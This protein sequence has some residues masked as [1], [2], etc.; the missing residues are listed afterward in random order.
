MFREGKKERPET[1][2]DL[3]IERSSMCVMGVE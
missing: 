1:V 2:L 3:A